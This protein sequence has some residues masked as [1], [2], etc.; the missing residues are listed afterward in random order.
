MRR[1][2][3]IVA[4]CLTWSLHSAGADRVEECAD[5]AERG[6]ELRDALQLVEARA[7]MVACAQSDCPAVVSTSCTEWLSD[8]DKRIPSFVVSAKDPQGRDLTAV[9]VSLD[10][11]AIANEN[12]ARAVRANPGAHTIRCE[13]DGYEPVNEQVLL[14]EG[15]GVRVV[16][17][18]LERKA[19]PSP[20]PS[21]SG[22][23][24]PLAYV[25][26]GTSLV[27]LG[28]FA[29]FGASGAS[30]YRRLESECAPRCSSSDI[31][32]V[33]TRFVVADVS[34]VVGILAAGG[35]AAL[36]LLDGS[37]AKTRA[38]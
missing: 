20:A 19:G 36:V 5:Q 37:P 4:A 23:I 29:Y 33:K 11:V 10:G 14:R 21:T 34:L 18:T 24:P 35:A 13:V 9:R 28:L 27:A 15:E 22:R 3:G 16:G 7:L 38:K 12:A 32:D 31:S 1:A 25:L 26:G 2:T 30:E 6:Q 17:V 8:I